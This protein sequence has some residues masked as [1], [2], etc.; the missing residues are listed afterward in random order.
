MADRGF[1]KGWLGPFK[2][3]RRYTTR[4]PEPEGSEVGR[5]YEAHH[6]LTRNPALVLIPSERAPLEPQEE[7]RVRLRSQAEPPYLS[8]E[9]EAAPA[10]GR[11]VQLRGALELLARAVE[12]LGNGEEA[13]AHLTRRPRGPLESL[14]HRAGRAWRW[15]RASR[16]RTFG[17]CFAMYLCLRLAVHV[18]EMEVYGLNWDMSPRVVE[19]EVPV[20]PAAV[21]RAP[22]LINKASVGQRPIAYPLPGKPFD[23]QAKAPCIPEEGEV[24]INGGCW[25][26]LEK[27]PPCF[28]SQAEYKGK[29]YLPVSARSRNTR[30][31]RSMRP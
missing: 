26:A 11:L 6:A 30:E 27:R 1:F 8:L 3:I 29:C 28:N 4:K 13:R 7:W 18:V 9:V 19:R 23:D 31:P 17:V 16:W 12:W 21:R 5:V 10:S 14:R 15:T 22:V 24:E 2:L 25:V 20:R